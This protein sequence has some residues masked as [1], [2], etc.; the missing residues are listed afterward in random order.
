MAYPRDNIWVV[1][2]AIASLPGR[3]VEVLT[4]VLPG[5]AAEID[6]RN[7]VPGE[8]IEELRAAGAFD[9]GSLGLG[10]LLEAVRLASRSSPGTAHVI[11][12]H[13]TSV[14]AS[15]GRAGSRGIVAFSMTEPG[16]G[17][18][19]IANL[20]TRALEDGGAARISG[21]KV[22]TSNAAYAGEFLVLAMGP[23]GPTLYLVPRGDGVRVELLELSGFRGS[24]VGRVEYREAPGTRVGAPGR[25]LREALQGINVGRLG[26]AAIALGM[27]ESMIE[28]AYR[29]ASGKTVFGRGLLEL[30]GPRWMLAEVYRRSILLEALIREAVSRARDGWIVD[31]LLAAAAK[32]EAGSLA[33]D[34]VWTGIQLQGGRG[35]ALGSTGER[36]WRDSRVLDIGEGSR[37]VL[38]DFI[39]SRLHKTLSG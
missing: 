19:V 28:S 6:R 20:K 10:G 25:G 37:E 36:L 7:L 12:V 26:Y 2:V 21:V 22:F 24:G 38:M 23:E 16:G 14:L 35:L 8:L 1:V 11:L 13:G 34:A 39:W 5:V 32:V 17:S 29:S 31:P 30:Q 27:A 18:D 3:L 4:S 9:V 15:G 33:R